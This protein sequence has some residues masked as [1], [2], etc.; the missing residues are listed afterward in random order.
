MTDRHSFVGSEEVKA[1]RAAENKR[2]SAAAWALAGWQPIETAPRDGRRVLV[3]GGGE[4]LT[5]EFTNG[6]FVVSPLQSGGDGDWAGL[7]EPWGELTH[8]MPLPPPPDL[9]FIALDEAKEGKPT[10]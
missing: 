4:I 9:A 3:A 7:A 10:S 6:R 2:I 8:W 5:A 1:A